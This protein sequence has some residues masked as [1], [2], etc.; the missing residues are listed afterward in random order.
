MHIYFR[1]LEDI[2]PNTELLVWYGNE[3]AKELGLID[4]TVLPLQH[5]VTVIYRNTARGTG[6]FKY[7]VIP[8]P[9]KLINLVS[10][11]LF[12]SCKKKCTFITLQLLTMWDLMLFSGGHTTANAV[13]KKTFLVSRR[14]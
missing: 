7:V 12:N 5:E 4:E 10:Y 9:F 6:Y 3:Y 2:A 13:E 8:Q 14:I 11:C 1:V